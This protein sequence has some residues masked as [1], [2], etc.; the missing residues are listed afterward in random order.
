[1]NKNGIRPIE[2]D[3]L[4]EDI[5]ENDEESQSPKKKAIKIP[6][7]DLI[8]LL[9]SIQKFFTTSPKQK[10]A[11][12]ALILGI[13]VIIYTGLLLLSTKSPGQSKPEPEPKQSPKTQTEEEKTLS[14]LGNK[15][16]EF[17]TRLNNLDNYRQKLSQPIVNLDIRFEL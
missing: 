5:Q 6:K 14:E 13:I 1:M 7:I 2:E 11:T 12:L 15:I 3:I 16:E 17:N 10:F 4:I 9:L 8:K